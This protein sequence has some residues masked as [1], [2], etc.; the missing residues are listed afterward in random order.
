MKNVLIIVFI[1]IFLVGC[2]STKRISAINTT[3]ITPPATLYNCP[4]LGKLPN[5][6]T[7]TNQEVADVISKLYRYNKIC[8]INMDQIQK[9]VEAAGKA[10]LQ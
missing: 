9:F 1:S 7:L 10:S 6:E 8:K 4:Q 2:N 5:P 3:V